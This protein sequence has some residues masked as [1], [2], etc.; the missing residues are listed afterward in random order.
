MYKHCW[1]GDQFVAKSMFSIL[2]KIFATHYRIICLASEKVLEDPKCI[3]GALEIV[4][5]TKIKVCF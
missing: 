2:P 3:E 1:E 4:I 5:L